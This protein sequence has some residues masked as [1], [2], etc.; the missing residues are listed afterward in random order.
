MIFF[1]EIKLN[2]R[3]CSKKKKRLSTQRFELTLSLP[4]AREYSSHL[5]TL[6]LKTN[7]VKLLQFKHFSLPYVLF[8]ACGAVFIMNAK[9]HLTKISLNEYFK[10]ILHYFGI[11]SLVGFTADRCTE[12]S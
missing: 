6:A 9:I 8:E 10:V 3:K 5:P 4:P 7:T 2:R 12:L 11:N 1:T